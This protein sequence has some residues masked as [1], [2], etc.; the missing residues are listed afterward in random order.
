VPRPPDGYCFRRQPQVL[1]LILLRIIL[2]PHGPAD[3][4]IL[5]LLAR[6]NEAMGELRGVVTNLNV[7]VLNV[8]S[9]TVRLPEIT[10][11]V[12]NEA[13]DLPGLVQQTQTSMRELERLIEAMQHH[14]LLRKYVNP[15]NP[16]PS[17]PLLPSGESPRQPTKAFRSPKA[18]AQ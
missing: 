10:E 5:L 15:T 13:K 2:E 3:R 12:A 6:A 18:A 1:T 16:P 7:A 9:G 8:Q 11:A 17:Q 4:W 14:W